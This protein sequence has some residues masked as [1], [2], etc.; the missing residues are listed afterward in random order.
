MSM[1]AVVSPLLVDIGVVAGIVAALSAAA[2]VPVI[3]R[4]IH[5]VWRQLVAAPL[6]AWFGRV[7]VETMRPEVDRLHGRIDDLRDTLAPMAQEMKPNGGK[8][9]KDQVCR[10]AGDPPGTSPQVGPVD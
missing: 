4:P 9:M 1:D 2:K 5:F 6:A 8:S 3:G 10:I 7:I